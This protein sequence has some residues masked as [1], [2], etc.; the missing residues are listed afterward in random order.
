MQTCKTPS[1]PVHAVIVGVGAVELGTAALLSGLGCMV[2][3]IDADPARV[4][5]LSA[6]SFPS[7]D[8]W[9]QSAVVEAFRTGALK[10]STD[11]VAAIQ[12]SSCV[13]LSSSMGP[14][15]RHCNLQPA[16][17]A[18][19]QVG[20]AFRALG[21][22][23]P[24]IVQSPVPN[25]AT[26]AV[27]Q[28]ISSHFDYDECLAFNPPPYLMPDGEDAVLVAS[29]CDGARALLTNIYMPRYGSSRTIVT[30]L[31]AGESVYE[32]TRAAAATVRS[33]RDSVRPSRVA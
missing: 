16:F 1:D 29:D 8:P 28:V 30:G 3:C 21:A 18:A 11:I 19:R 7:L 5:S 12:E 31:S 6:G 14:S 25:G 26:R 23:V 15:T 22:G 20:E 10:F 32:S 9:T 2:K 4:G 27:G 24:V 13:F 17:A 33:R